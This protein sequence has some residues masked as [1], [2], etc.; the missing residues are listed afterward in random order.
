MTRARWNSNLRIED[1]RN[2]SY[3]AVERL[4]RLL[5]DGAG[6]CEDPHRRDFYEVHDDAAVYYIYS[7]PI[8]GKVYLLATSQ[9]EAS[10]VTV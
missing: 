6:V 7:S 2:H 3:E 10:P 1:P 8:T 5:A 4:R 9:K